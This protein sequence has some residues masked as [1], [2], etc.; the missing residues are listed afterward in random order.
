MNKKNVN[1]WKACI[2]S[3]SLMLPKQSKGQ[4]LRLPIRQFRSDSFL[5]RNIHIAGISSGFTPGAGF[6]SLHSSRDRGKRYTIPG[7]ENRA[8][9]NFPVIPENDL[10]C[11]KRYFEFLGQVMYR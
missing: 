7:M 8:E 3:T 1:P 9:A 2:S 4:P 11:L 10:H 5:A 6:M